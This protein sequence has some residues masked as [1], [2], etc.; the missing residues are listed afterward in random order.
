MI[1][2]V[3]VIAL[4]LEQVR[5]LEPHNPAAAALRRWARAVAH[6]V[7][8]G[9]GHHAWLAWTLVVALP[10]LAAA[11]VHGLLLWLGGWPLALLWSVLVLYLTLGFRQFSHHFTGI[12]D[13]LEAGDEE[14]ARQLL[15]HWQ[16]VDAGALPRTEIVRL[17]IEY[18]VLAAHRHVFGVLA[19]FC[20]LAVAGLGPAGAVFY[21]N[22]E[23]VRRYWQRKTQA[24]DHPSSP[25][26][27]EAGD[28]AWRV[29]DWLPARMTA[30]GLA[31]VGS[32]E[33]AIDAWRQHAARFADANDGVIL[34]ATAGAIGVR[35]GG[36]SLRPAAPGGLGQPMP[37]A[38]GL[39][40]EGLPGEPPRTAHF[41][42]V[43]G[44]VWRMVALWL[45]LLVL[46]TLAHVLG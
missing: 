4:L 15:A 11:A 13:A 16:Q 32:F 10:A 20:V 18:S 30:L 43:V 38:A 14:R 9:T 19:W 36:A 31:I 33:D 21:R 44:L 7:D 2:F 25:A 35:L 37:G 8:T 26:L 6:N 39:A 22:A 28:A 27:C 24:A 17:V 45:L 42:Q 12:R 5:P 34:A 23:F 29:I 41:T 46:L 3:I 40:A 1:L